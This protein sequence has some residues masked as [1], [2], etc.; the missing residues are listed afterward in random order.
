MFW[1]YVHAQND[2][3]RRVITASRYY[4]CKLMPVTAL[5]TIIFFPISYNKCQNI[6][7]KD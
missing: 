2:P 4:T 3:T 5:D 1:L 7:I 6:A